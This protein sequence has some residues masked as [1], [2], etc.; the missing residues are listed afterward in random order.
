MSGVLLLL[1]DGGESQRR[2]SLLSGLCRLRS[3][4]LWSLLLGGVLDLP[5]LRLGGEGDR[6]LLGGL[7]SGEPLSLFRTGDR[8]S[9]ESALFFLLGG[10]LSRDG[11]LAPLLGGLDSGVS[12]S[13][14]RTGDKSSSESAF[15][16]LLGGERSG[17]AFLALRGGLES[18]SFLFLL[19]GGDSSES[20]LFLLTSG[21]AFLLGDKSGLA[22]RCRRG[23]DVSLSLDWPPK[24]TL[25]SFLSSLFAVFLIFPSLS[26][27]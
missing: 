26:V 10:D 21:E 1:L 6:R 17:E 13:P 14:L 7:L 8:S 15:L 24:L 11:L 2:F 19:L 27:S 18:L 22:P 16:A 12:L 20:R 3:G 9:S 23:G 5:L 4:D 25:L